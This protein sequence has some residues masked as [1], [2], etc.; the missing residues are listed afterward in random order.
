MPRH[1]WG[2]AWFVNGID[3]VDEKIWKG[4]QVVVFRP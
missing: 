3:L 4:E 2:L 1:R